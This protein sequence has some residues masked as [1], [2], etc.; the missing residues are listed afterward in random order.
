MAKYWPDPREM[1]EQLNKNAEQETGAFRSL[2]LTFYP[3]VKTMLTRQRADGKLAAELARETMLSV[4][5]KWDGVSSGSAEDAAWIYSTAR[6][7]RT[8][9]VRHLPVWQRSPDALEGQ[10]SP[11][12]PRAWEHERDKI[13]GAL[14]MLAP[15]QLQVIQL[16]FLDGLAPGEIASRLD[17]PLGTVKSRLRLAFGTVCGS[18]ERSA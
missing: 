12:E 4:W 10:A 16:S 9:R 18:E 3:K 13:E 7:L 14:G 5:R 2:F 17:L 6:D 1:G 8:D 15:E 11:G